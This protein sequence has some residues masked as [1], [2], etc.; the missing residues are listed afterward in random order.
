MLLSILFHELRIAVDTVF[1]PPPL[2][3]LG[4][5]MKKVVLP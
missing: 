5:L 3:E 1:P 4:K 2:A